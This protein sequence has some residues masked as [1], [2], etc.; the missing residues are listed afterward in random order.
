M[1][2]QARNSGND[3]GRKALY[4]PMW[5]RCTSHSAKR[6]QRKITAIGKGE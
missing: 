1:N 4:L 5:C 3:K 2:K 6:L